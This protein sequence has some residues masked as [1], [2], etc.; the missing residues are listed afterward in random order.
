MTVY[1]KIE[2]DNITVYENVTFK[3]NLIHYI[4]YIV[5]EYYRS[6]CMTGESDEVKISLEIDYNKNKFAIR[7][8]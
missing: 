4:N 3:E 6:E 2:G 8:K 5:N 1:L 7:L